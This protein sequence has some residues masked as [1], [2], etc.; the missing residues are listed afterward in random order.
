M[1]LWVKKLTTTLVILAAVLTGCEQSQSKEQIADLSPSDVK[2]LIDQ[3]RQ[4]LI[5]DV[6]TPVEFTGELGH[7]PGSVLR[8]V[9]EIEEWI[10]E[11]EDRKDQE[12]VV[13]CRSGNRSGYA[14]KYL[15]NRAFE[16]VS[17]MR[18]GMRAWNKNKY[19]VSREIEGGEV[20]P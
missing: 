14:T 9:Q 13:V 1:R 10:R 20:L 19:P 8:P 4:V 18:G 11:F 6:R 12:I 16:N 2:N 7:I 17:N 15:Q 3:D 5:I